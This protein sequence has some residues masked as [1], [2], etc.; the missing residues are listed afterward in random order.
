M[1]RN[2][3]R[4]TRYTVHSTQNTEHSRVG[5][6]ELYPTVRSTGTELAASFPARGHIIYG[7]FRSYLVQGTR[8]SYIVILRY[9]Y[10]VEL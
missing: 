9:E 3:V 8:Y 4:M 6:D 7:C 5:L 1:T 2:L 10:I